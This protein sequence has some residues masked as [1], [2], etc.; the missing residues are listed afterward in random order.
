M[1]SVISK[2]SSVLMALLVL[3]ST[4]SFT[5]E[6]H[7]CGD[8]LVAI[9]FFGEANNCA[10]ELEED[11]CDSPEVLQEKNCC[12]NEIQNI[13]GQDDLRNSLEKF[14]L[15]KQQFLVAF[16]TSFNDLFL[17]EKQEKKENIHHLPPKLIQDLQVLHEV[18]II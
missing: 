9:S 1:K 15:D 3:F 5:I 18:Y 6:K 17:P 4:F 14:D 2:I 12:K 13:E 11:D 16:V 10:D 7:Y 8:F